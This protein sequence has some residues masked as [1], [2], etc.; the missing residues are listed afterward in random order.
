MEY[1]KKLLFSIFFA[2]LSFNVFAS[3]D[4]E[5][6]RKMAEEIS[7]NS[8]DYLRSEKTKQEI[9]S[10]PFK[11]ETNKSKEFE[12]A[13]SEIQKKS[14]DSVIGNFEEKT[15]VKSDLNKDPYD[16]KII[17][18]MT[19]EM[20]ESEFLSVLESVQ[21]V[22]GVVVFRG[23]H[24]EDKSIPETFKRFNAFRK[25][26][27]QLAVNL[28]PKIFRENNVTS[29]PFFIY[30]DAEKKIKVSAK[31]MVSP[32]SIMEDIEKNK[33]VNV[34]NFKGKSFDIAEK[35]ILDEIKQRMQAINWDE[36]KKGAQDR[37]WKKN[38]Q[39]VD[40]LPRADKYRERLIDLSIKI[41]KD[42]IIN[43]ELKAK[44]GQ[45][46]NPFDQMNLN[47]TLIILDPFVDEQLVLAKRVASKAKT[48]KVKFI[49]NNVDRENG[50][51]HFDNLY[52]YLG[53]NTFL[54]YPDMIERFKIEK[55]LSVVYQYGKKLKVDEL[56]TKDYQYT[57]EELREAEN[58]RKW[59]L[60]NNLAK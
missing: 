14:F 46:L 16:K 5:K 44:A 12:N 59:K 32:I 18:F 24:K 17:A 28:D 36:K 25:Q 53:I 42:Q 26:F 6:A 58:T 51:E 40:S 7:N 10:L 35:D 52:K 48:A 9:N 21:K 45:V 30:E 43:G 39:M 56:Y 2:S 31:G 27:P 38:A 1:T 19:W 29:A 22:N 37:Y 13:S 23:L 33:G 47:T 50:W 8:K 60:N 55:T 20:P 54:L 15:G 41:D 34:S 57:A 3:V 11:D 49:L 4:Q